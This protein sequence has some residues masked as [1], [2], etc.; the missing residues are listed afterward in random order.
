MPTCVN[1]TSIDG[2]KTWT[3]KEG[4]SFWNGKVID[5]RPDGVNY[6]SKYTCSK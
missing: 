3:T 4:A 6:V 2:K 5:G 1:H